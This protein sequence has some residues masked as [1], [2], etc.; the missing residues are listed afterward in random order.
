MRVDGV[1]DGP[2]SAALS[3]DFAFRKR[4]DG[5]YTVSSGTGT[6]ADVV[7]DSVR[8]LRTFLPLAAAERRHT[9]LRFGRRFFQELRQLARWPLDEA[10][11][12]EGERI[13]DPSASARELDDGLRKLKAAFPAFSSAVIRQRW[14]GLIDATPDA[15][16]V[17]S[18]VDELPGFY[19]ATGFSGH[20][21]G[22]GPGA[23]RL[24]ADLITGHH[25]HRRSHRLPLLPLHRWIAPNLLH[26]FIGL[27]L[28]AKC[29]RNW[30]SHH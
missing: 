8:F 9:K 7:P 23:G 12:F 4:A 3:S 16:P 13:L 18:A 29:R 26:W 28:P 11:P 25:A 30:P 1:S 14:A 24:M 15:I 20:G 5:G 27:A 6:I 22:M 17:I 10:S 2:E 19:V 21:F